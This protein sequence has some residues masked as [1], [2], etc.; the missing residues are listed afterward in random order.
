[1][2]KPSFQTVYD[3]TVTTGVAT[4]TAG[5]YLQYGVPPALMAFG[6]LV[7]ALSVYAAERMAR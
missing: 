3:L 6:A 7:I 4:V 5:V 1:M 2:K